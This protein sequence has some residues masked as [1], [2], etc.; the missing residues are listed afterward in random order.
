MADVEELLRNAQHAFQNI[1][2]GSTD[3]KKYAARAKRLALSVIRKSPNSIEGGQARAIMRGLRG[4]AARTTP[5]N[6]S[7]EAHPSRPRDVSHSTHPVATVGT[8]S[9]RAQ[10]TSDVRPDENSWANIW[11]LFLSLSNRMKKIVF[12]ALGI[13]V[14]FIGFTPFLLIFPLIYLFQADAI[15]K[16]IRQI[17]TMLQ[18]R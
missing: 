15:K 13:G 14:V 6:L 10:S 7:H 9:V 8:Q 1:S 2:P 18:S 4:D 5:K 17:L 16:H 3:E 12:V 11:Q